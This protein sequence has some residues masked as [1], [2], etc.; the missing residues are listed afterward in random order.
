MNC[1]DMTTWQGT[2]ILVPA[3]AARHHALFISD[4]IQHFNCSSK[5]D[6]V[7]DSIAKDLYVLLAE[8]FEMR[9]MSKWLRR[10]LM[11][12]VKASF[13]RSINR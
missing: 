8:V 7:R 13:G 6:S 10:T 9:G 12:F 3:M 4:N 5:E 1:T 11:V 2:G